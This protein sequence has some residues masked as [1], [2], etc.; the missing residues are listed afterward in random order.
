MIMT[1]RMDKP[2]QSDTAPRRPIRSYV[3]REGRMTQAQQ[4]A[5]DEL[6]ARY[7]VPGDGH[8]LDPQ[9]LFGRRAPLVVEIGF[10]N[11][12]SLAAMAA[13]DP[14]RDYLGIEVH[15]PGVGHLLNRIE[16]LALTNVRVS[17]EDAVEVLRDRLEDGSVTRLQLFFPDPWPKKRH[18]KRRMVQP[19]WAALVSRKLAP[20]GILHMATDWEPYAQHMLEVME[21]RP[22]FT[23]CAGPG[24]F[25]PDRGHRPE[26][27]FER[28]G[29][30]RGHGVWDL[31]YARKS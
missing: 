8:V 16:E 7:G 27:K 2:A 20:G 21:S 30:G 23:N 11:G 15:R 1:E 10:G 26:T 6:Y 3:R 5:L 14:E 29:L 28:R 12:E 25:A 9:A 17:C 18:H 13:A 4:R 19:A 22:E 24:R 31:M